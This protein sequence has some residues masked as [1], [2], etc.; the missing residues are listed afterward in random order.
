MAKTN[1]FGGEKQN[2]KSNGEQ[3]DLCDL[4]Q[5]TLK[6][7]LQVHHYLTTWLQI[8]YYSLLWGDCIRKGADLEKQSCL[9]GVHPAELGKLF[10][11]FL[12]YANELKSV[13][14]SLSILQCQKYP[15]GMGYALNYR[16]LTE[17]NKK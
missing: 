4:E 17:N 15:E 16:T 3:S 1:T 6:P 7:Q 12:K 13:V 10:F 14:K 9:F 11:F 2:R 5:V 8:W